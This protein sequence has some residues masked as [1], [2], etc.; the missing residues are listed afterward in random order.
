MLQVKKFL[1]KM[2]RPHRD[3][4]VQ[5]HIEGLILFRQEF[6]NSI[7]LEVFILP[8]YNDNTEELTRL[9]EIIKKN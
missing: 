1:K 6:L 9:K 3:L 2:N 4:N 7:W 5:M 8:G